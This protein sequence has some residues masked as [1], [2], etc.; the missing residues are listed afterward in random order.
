MF[1]HSLENL[2]HLLPKILFIRNPKKVDK[3]LILEILV[4]I[5]FSV[6]LNSEFTTSLKTF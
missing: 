6:F 3:D 4:R 5:S 1:L 2:S